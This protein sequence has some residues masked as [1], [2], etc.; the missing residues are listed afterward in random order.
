MTIVPLG[1]IVAYD[2]GLA[3]GV[4]ES[5]VGVVLM[6]QSGAVPAGTTA[7]PL[8]TSQTPYP[9]GAVALSAGSAV[10]ANASAVATLT[11]T[12]TTT[13]YISGF[14]ITGAGATAGL[15]VTVTVAGLLGGTRSFV[16]TFAVGATLPNT[17]L[18]V[19]FNPPLP[20]SGVNTPIVVTC[21]AG[22]VGNTANVANAQ[23]FYL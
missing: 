5:A 21:P 20:A 16:Y 3:G 22:G 18:I 2:A 14:E 1:D 13:V 8:V 6:S 4:K 19:Q 7:S 23:G 10:V 15:P 12:A 9:S 17:P 11:G